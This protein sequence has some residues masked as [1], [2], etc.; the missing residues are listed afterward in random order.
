MKGVV[1]ATKRDRKAFCIDDL[2]YSVYSPSQMDG[3]EKGCEVE[4]DF[5]KKGEWNNVKGNVKVLSSDGGTA[6]EVTVGKASLARERSIVRQNALGHAT[7]LCISQGFDSDAD[8]NISLANEIVSI[9]RVFEAYATGDSDIAEAEA[10]LKA[11]E[12][13]DSE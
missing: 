9:A 6:V 3:V 2:W 11:I 10:A 13:G 12:G 7:A 4:F 8:N 1:E 5:I